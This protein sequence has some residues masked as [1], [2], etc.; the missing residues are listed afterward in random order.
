MASAKAKTTESAAPQESVYTAQEL[1][2]N[3]KL[4][5]ASYEIVTVA[6]RKAGKETATRSEAKKIIEKFKKEV[7]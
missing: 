4:F 1:A 6:L 5:Q 7:K 2:E 3:S